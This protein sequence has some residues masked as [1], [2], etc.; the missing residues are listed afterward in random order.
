M[1]QPAIPVITT[2]DTIQILRAQLRKAAM[3]LG[4][5]AIGFRDLGKTNAHDCVNRWSEDALACLREVQ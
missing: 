5:A 4:V 3:Q 1:T 2:E